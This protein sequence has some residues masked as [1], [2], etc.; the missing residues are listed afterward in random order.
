MPGIELVIVGGHRTLPLAGDT[1]WQAA[2]A[3]DVIH[4]AV[5]KG[6]L[7]GVGAKTPEGD[8]LAD[9]AAFDLL[10]QVGA[11]ELH[12]DGVI[13]TGGA[14]EVFFYED[15][16]VTGGTAFGTA[17]TPQN[18]KRTSSNAL[19]STFY[20]SPGVSDVGNEITNLFVPGGTGGTKTG[21]TVRSGAEWE[22]APGKI[23][24]LR[25]YNRSGGAI[26]VGIGLEVYEE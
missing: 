23:Y 16:Q 20:K 8:N 24:L 13:A 6:R 3:I 1:V 10:L 5:H 17:I 15:T 2:V 19:L 9:N 25:V 18:R 26:P 14:A 11:N 7:F 21:S 4:L 12:F 22:L